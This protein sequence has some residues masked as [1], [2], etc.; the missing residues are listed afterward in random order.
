M[1]SST[2]FLIVFAII[3]AMVAIPA[4]MDYAR[5][6]VMGEAFSAIE[7]A[8]T[9]STYNE[10]PLP[11]E[12]VL[13]NIRGLLEN[14]HK[15]TPIQCAELVDARTQAIYTT[16]PAEYREEYTQEQYRQNLEK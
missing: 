4:I 9:V 6:A 3:L 8:K 15:N 14:V 10:D 2:L 5:N 1:K 7:V 16:L 12:Q 11:R 13:A